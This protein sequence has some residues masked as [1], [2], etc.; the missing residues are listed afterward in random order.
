MIPLLAPLLG[1]LAGSLLPATLGT[2]I[3]S[4]L[5]LSGAAG[6]LVAAAAPK[7]IG[8]GIGTLLAGGDLGD[9]ALNAIGFGAAGALGGAGS[10]AAGA[11]APAAAS[12]APAAAAA[13]PAAAA[14]LPTAVPTAATQ[15]AGASIM[16][17]V[18]MASRLAPMLMGG[19]QQPVMPSMAPTPPQRQGQSASDTALLA[20]MPRPAPSMSAGAPPTVPLVGGPP[21]MPASA[22]QGIGALGFN[23]MQEQ[24]MFPQGGMMGGFV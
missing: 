6:S 15:G 22:T 12:A 16:R 20:N 23:R 4:A 9:A 3:A 17:N 14:A 21:V 24:R 11:A 13:A 7:A 2:G 8:A 18:Q 19:Q 5:G 1:S 10:A